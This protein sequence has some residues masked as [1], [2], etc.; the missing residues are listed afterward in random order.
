MLQ[1]KAQIEKL[2]AELQAILPRLE[3]Q[4]AG[5]D[6]RSRNID[7]TQA[8][9]LL[10]RLKTFSEDWDRPETAIYAM[11]NPRRGDV[12]LVLFPNSDLKTAKRRPALLRGVG[13]ETRA[14]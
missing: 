7:E 9:D 5:V 3:T 10:S 1:L 14:V 12:V 13:L 2:Q 11:I 4:Q 8:A 6:L